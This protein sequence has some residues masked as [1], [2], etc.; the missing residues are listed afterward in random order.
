MNY[1][2]HTLSA[3]STLALPAIQN[4]S[5][6]APSTGSTPDATTQQLLTVLNNLNQ[7]G[8]LDSQHLKQVVRAWD[9]GGGHHWGSH[10]SSDSS[11]FPSGTSTQP[12]APQPA[13]TSGSSDSTSDSS[14]PTSSNPS[15]PA[16]TSGSSDPTSSNPSQP[17]S[18]SGSSDPTSSNPSQPVSTS[19]SSDSTSGSSDPTSSNPSQSDPTSGSSDP[20][21]NNPQPTSSSSSADT[22]TSNSQPSSTTSASSSSGSSTP[23]SSGVGPGSVAAPT[24]SGPSFY[25]SA[26]GN[27]SNSGTSADKAFQ[28]IQSAVNA[29]NGQGGTIYLE[30]GTY[31]LSDAVKI[32]S[33]HGGTANQHLVITN[34][35][36]AHPILDGSG[37]P[38]GWFNGN[39]TLDHAKYVDINGIET[40]NGNY[41]IQGWG[42]QNC[43]V[44]NSISHDNW[45]AGIGFLSPTAGGE[46]AHNTVSGNT[47]YHNETENNNHDHGWGSAIMMSRSDDSTVTNNNVYEN[48]GEGIDFAI[49]NGF[50]AL[51]NVTHDN[52]SVD[53]YL[54]NATNGTVQ[55]NTSISQQNPTYFREE[56]G[57][58]SPAYGLMIANENYEASNPSANITIKNND[59]ENH[60][61]D[62]EAGANMINNTIDGNTFKNGTWDVVDFNGTDNTNTSFTNN[63]ITQTNSSNVLGQNVVTD[64]GHVGKNTNGITFSGNTWTGNGASGL[65]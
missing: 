43:S 20:V 30:D 22:G 65:N 6:N 48:Q 28:S 17:T 7:A 11:Q 44:T 63:T 62:F 13:P 47:V 26:T 46:S 24:T 49:V 10:H 12:T 51:N 1:N 41:G 37:I 21:A 16:S 60:V 35:D 53:M 64:P 56:Y 33:S 23:V 9:H 31:K 42:A 36:G 27:D 45:E 2:A 50:K 58:P 18:T 34:A 14:D 5:A 55:N 54:D 38:Q 39:I 29:A 25:V 52:F 57:A 32:D 15:Q 3:D 59:F 19:G 8:L 61:V 4:A 40:K